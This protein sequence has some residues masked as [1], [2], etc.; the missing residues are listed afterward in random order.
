[1]FLGYCDQ[2]RVTL[3]GGGEG[4]PQSEGMGAEATWWTTGRSASG[5]RLRR[6]PRTESPSEDS[7]TS[8]LVISPSGPKQ[9]GG[10]GA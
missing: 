4:L 3:E 9:T 1:M 2:T 7:G 6:R 5:E 10:T 8:S